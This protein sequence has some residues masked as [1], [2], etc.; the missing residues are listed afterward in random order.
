M[1]EIVILLV[2]AMPLPAFSQPFL[3]RFPGA[4]L[5]PAALVA[6]GIRGWGTS[7]RCG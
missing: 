4:A 3:P 2:I 7:S 1:L 6:A 5:L